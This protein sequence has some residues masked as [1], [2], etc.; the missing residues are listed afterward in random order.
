MK[1]MMDGRSGRSDWGIKYLP[2]LLTIL[3]RTA[4]G[5]QLPS[6]QA[7]SRLLSLSVSASAR[8]PLPLQPH[9][10]SF[11]PRSCLMSLAQS[12]VAMPT[13]ARQS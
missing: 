7:P 1:D 9:P 2:R 12:A 13:R 3:L 5:K 11:N 8:N 4:S 6:S 10:Y